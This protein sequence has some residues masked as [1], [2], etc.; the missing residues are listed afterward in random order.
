MFHLRSTSTPTH[1]PPL[2]SSSPPV[3]RCPQ[4]SP[5]LTWRE[6][7]LRGLLTVFTAVTTTCSSRESISASWLTSWLKLSRCRNKRTSYTTCTLKSTVLHC[8]LS[9]RAQSE[10]WLV[11]AEDLTGIRILTV[12]IVARCAI[13]LPSSTT[14]QVRVPDWFGFQTKLDLRE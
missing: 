5:T 4:A 7:W 9:H 12:K 8:F 1:M 2:L 13:C 10:C 11:F 3:C 14:K 6:R